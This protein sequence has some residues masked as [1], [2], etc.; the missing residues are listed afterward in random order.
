MK[1]QDTP[2]QPTTADINSL[3]QALLKLT[4]TQKIITVAVIAV[5]LLIWYVLLQRLIQFG[6]GIDYSGLHALGVPTV[7]LLQQYNPFFW[8]AVVCLCTLII[9]WLLYGF[10]QSQQRRGRHA[11]VKEAV[12]AGLAQQLSEPAREVLCWVWK[13]QRQPINVGDLQRTLQELRHGRSNKITLARQ[14]AA[15]LSAQPVTSEHND[16]TISGLRSR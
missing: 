6:R 2:Q 14:H 8:W 11:L 1:Q 15:L 9:V 5:T 3:R 13:D 7:N 4:A 10:A 12:I 16:H